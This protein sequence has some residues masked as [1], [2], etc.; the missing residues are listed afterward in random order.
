MAVEYAAWIAERDYE[1]FKEMLAP[2]MPDSYELWLRVR[3]RGRRRA[4]EESSVTFEEVEVSPDEFR[5]FCTRRTRPE[6]NIYGL[7]LYA[8]EKAFAERR[9]K[10]ANG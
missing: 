4:F 8:R 5:T 1:A 2:I 3:E 10:A 9:A 7:D 6:F